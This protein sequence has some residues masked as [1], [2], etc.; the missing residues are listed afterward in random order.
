MAKSE[1]PRLMH[2]T[3]TPRAA[4][5]AGILF[6]VL[7]TVSIVLLQLSMP[8]NFADMNAWSDTTRHRAAL[9]LGLMPVAGLAFLWFVGVVRDRL[10]AYEDQFFAAVFQGSGLLFLAMTFSAFAMAAGMLAAYRI[11]GDAIMTSSIYLVG[12][13]IISQVFSTYALKMAAVFM[14]SLST[15]WLRTGVMPR[16]LCF[17]SYA[18]AIVMFVSP[19][20]SLWV[21]LSFP[22]WVFCISVYIL[23]LSS[24]RKPSGSTDGT[25]PNLEANQVRR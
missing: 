6:G 11:G 1:T 23:V 24:R 3:R 16:G 7:F 21:V 10:G 18:M 9:A 4:A 13:S 17:F 14:F 19:S 8:P 22:A 15:L 20:L 5:I 12:R 25:T 2:R